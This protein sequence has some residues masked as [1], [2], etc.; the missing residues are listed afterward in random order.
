MSLVTS[1]PIYIDKTDPDAIALTGSDTFEATDLFIDLPKNTVRTD[2]SRVTSF[3]VLSDTDG[4]T[5]KNLKGVIDVNLSDVSADGIVTVLGNEEA[6]TITGSQGH[7][8]IDAAA[9]IRRC[10][11]WRYI[12]L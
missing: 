4:E 1:P 6:N 3:K 10:R 9:L 11:S 2:G 8:F 5:A 7:D 12:N